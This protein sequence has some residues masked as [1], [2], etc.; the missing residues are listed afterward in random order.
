MPSIKHHAVGS[1]FQIGYAA[2][3]IEEGIRHLSDTLRIGP[4]YTVDSFKMPLQK[5]RGLETPDLDV[6]VAFSFLGDMMYEIVVQKDS[7]PS[8]YRD[9]IDERGC[10]LHHV[11]YFTHDFDGEIERLKGKGY[12]PAFE[13]RTGEDLGRKRVTYMDT[14]VQLGAM[15]E[16]CEYSETVIDLFVKIQEQCADWDGT[17]PV[18]DLS[19]LR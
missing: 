10:G 13:V 7:G 17:N 19:D 4:W 2:L 9:T 12:I 6:S 8:V 15:L 18:R 14:R 1:V 3:S 16:V 11:A 5:Y